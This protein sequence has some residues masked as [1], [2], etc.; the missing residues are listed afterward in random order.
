MKERV[1][2]VVVHPILNP[3]NDSGRVSFNEELLDLQ[4][5]D[6][7]VDVSPSCFKFSFRNRR[8]L[9]ALPAVRSLPSSDRRTYL[10]SSL[11]SRM[12]PSKFI[13]TNLRGGGS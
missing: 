8:V 1:Y 2:I 5:S 12:L 6:H 4:L 3:S 9:K 10:A 11:V 13:L 7:S